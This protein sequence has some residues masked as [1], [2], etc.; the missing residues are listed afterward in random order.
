MI[1]AKNP[2]RELGQVDLVNISVVDYQLGQTQTVLHPKGVY[3]LTLLVS[4][5][6]SVQ[7]N[8]NYMELKQRVS[9]KGSDPGTHVVVTP[10]LEL[11]IGCEDHATAWIKI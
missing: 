10:T 9:N 2:I 8:L 4:Q 1:P 7:M 3:S 6:I 5:C 11:V